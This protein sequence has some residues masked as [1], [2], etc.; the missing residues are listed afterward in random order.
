MLNSLSLTIH[1]D[2]IQKLEPEVDCLNKFTKI[3][4]ENPNHV[5][6]HNPKEQSQ[7]LLKEYSEDFNENSLDNSLG[8]FLYSF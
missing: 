6:K 3:I 8:D 1:F 4:Y 7:Q 5:S 2:D